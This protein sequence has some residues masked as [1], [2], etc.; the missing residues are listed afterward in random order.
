M[1]VLQGEDLAPAVLAESEA[2]ALSDSDAG[3]AADPEAATDAPDVEPQQEAEQEVGGGRQAEA[4]REAQLRHERMA[5]PVRPGLHGEVCTSEA[6]MSN[7]QVRSRP[8][9]C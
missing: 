1:D 4:E 8:L 9:L 2:A 7:R 6:G 3:S 5:R